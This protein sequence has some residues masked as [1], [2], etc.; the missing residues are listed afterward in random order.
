MIGRIIS[1]ERTVAQQQIV[2][3]KFIRKPQDDIFA[4]FLFF[5]YLPRNHFDAPLIGVFCWRLR[6]FSSVRDSSEQ[7]WKPS[8]IV[9]S[10]GASE[11]RVVSGGATL[12]HPFSCRSCARTVAYS[13]LQLSHAQ[14]C[15]LPRVAG[16]S[17]LRHRK[18]TFTNF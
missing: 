4:L 13:F 15:V 16:G 5:S 7:H 10:I 18:C 14:N 9:K 2:M 1:R 6:R 17:K 12:L 3:N 8:E 11:V